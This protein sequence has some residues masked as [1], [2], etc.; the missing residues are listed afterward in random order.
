MISSWIVFVLNIL[1]ILSI[2][3]LER[4]HP[5]EAALWTFVLILLPLV[6]IVLYLVL[7]ST[8]QIKITYWVRSK[9]L[10][11]WHRQ[12]VMEQL[13]Q[14]NSIPLS[15]VPD[16]LQQA[17]DLMYFN[18]TYCH[19][20]ITEHNQIE[21]ITSGKEKYDRLF[22]DIANAKSSI[23]IEY[24]GLHNDFV[25]QHLAQL[26]AEKAKEGVLVKVMFDWLGSFGTPMSMFRELR[27]H[28]GMVKRI[29]PFFTHFRNHR[30]I[31]VIDGLIAYT[32]G[33]NIGKKYLGYNPS[34]T[35]WRDTQ[36]R[37][38]GDAVYLLQ[39]YFLLDW[40]CACGANKANI[41]SEQFDLLFPEHTIQNH[42][43]CQV[44]TSGVET[45]EQFMKMSYF[46][47][48]SSAKQSLII[49]TPYFI[50]N[51][52]IL[53]AIKAASASGV[54]V[55]LMLPTCRSNFFLT[56]VSNFFV[57]QVMEYGVHV[58][59]YPGYIHAK[60][61]SIDG[62]ACSIG[63]VNMDVRSLEVDDEVTVFMFDEDFA[64]QYEE[65]IE[66]DQTLCTPLDVEQFRHRP[67][68]QKALER[69]Y[70]LFYPLM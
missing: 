33:M 68:H 19:A 34:K 47:M 45:D 15:Q 67:W 20:L 56:P 54:E 29:K 36:I 69:F 31:V 65:I 44:V 48:I 16:Q 42:L 12:K 21:Q 70:T 26:L 7:G 6:G 37:I 50:P 40:F 24:Y 58:Y 51:A 61:M 39:Y 43:V 38:Q 22:Q 46:K 35:P 3:F 5:A 28:G 55:T 2:L 63:S 10:T 59:L 14:V 23:H 13:D 62:I 30:K 8:M 1:V 25:G 41:P 53:D 49:Q 66:R 4:K 52:T 32:G 9:R 57:S 27:Q 11:D 64:K 60:T 17:A 18:L